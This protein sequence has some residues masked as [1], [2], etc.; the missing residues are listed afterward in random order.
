MRGKE[1]SG[2]H[3]SGCL[4]PHSGPFHADGCAGRICSLP[5]LRGRAGVG[6]ERSRLASC[7]RKP[8]R[9]PSIPH[10]KCGW[11]HA[12]HGFRLAP[13]PAFPRVRGKG[14]GAVSGRRCLSPHSGLFHADGCAGRICSLPCLRGR[15]GVGA[16]RSR[17]ASCQ[18]KPANVPH[19][20]CCRLDACH[21]FR[22]APIPAFPRMRG[23]GRRGGRRRGWLSRH[24]VPLRPLRVGGRRTPSRPA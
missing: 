11:L 22:L 21:G 12:C 19:S 16:E 14:Q 8:T 5:R 10:S 20:K 7:Q 15:V 3:R 13:I 24:S 4:S 17:L 6:A 23:K 9:A 2:E 1:R 18:R